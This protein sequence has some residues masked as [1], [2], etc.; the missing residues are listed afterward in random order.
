MLASLIR[1]SRRRGS[2][3]T[4]PCPFNFVNAGDSQ[5]RPY[6]FRRYRFDIHNRFRLKRLDRGRQ[7]LLRRQAIRAAAFD[8]FRRDAVGHLP[9]ETVNAL[10]EGIFEIV[11]ATKERVSVDG[12][13]P[14]R[15]RGKASIRA[16]CRRAR[17]VRPCRR[18][19]SAPSDDRAQCRNCRSARRRRRCGSGS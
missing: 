17:S 9:Q 4:R 16:T 7:H 8:S 12:L 13:S 11:E 15:Q 1:A 10:A 14:C 18:L 6:N 3:S 19:R 2:V 5:S